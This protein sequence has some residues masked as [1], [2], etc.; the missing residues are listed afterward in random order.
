MSI[1]KM[2]II[3]RNVW[4]IFGSV[5]GILG[6]ICIALGIALMCTAKDFARFV[7]KT[8]TIEKNDRAYG[9][10]FGIGVFVVCAGVALLACMVL[11]K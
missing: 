11:I 6:V 8:K 9:I 10:W 1:N 7:R 5:Y 2:D 3:L 4:D